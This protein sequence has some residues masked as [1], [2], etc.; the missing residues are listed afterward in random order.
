MSEDSVQWFEQLDLTDEQEMHVEREQGK[1][2]TKRERRKTQQRKKETNIT[3]SKPMRIAAPKIVGAAITASRT[4]IGLWS[5]RSGASTFTVRIGIITINEI[6]AIV[7]NGIEPSRPV[8]PIT[9]GPIANPIA[10]T[11]L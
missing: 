9:A 2:K 4:E 10:N 6:K 7:I 11:I 8:K 1:N 3:S 5:E